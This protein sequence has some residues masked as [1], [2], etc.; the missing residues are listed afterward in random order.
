MAV[1]LATGEQAL[2]VGR[3]DAG[4]DGFDD[5]I[6]LGFL[7]VELGRIRR[8]VFEPRAGQFV[9]AGPRGEIEEGVFGVFR[10]VRQHCAGAVIR[11]YAGQGAVGFELH[12]RIGVRQE[13]R[14]EADVG[15]AAGA[16]GFAQFTQADLKADGVLALQQF[17]EVGGVGGAAA[18]EPGGV[19]PGHVVLGPILQRGLQVGDGQLG[20]LAAGLLEI[21]A[22]G[23]E[24]LG[25]QGVGRETEDGL[26]GEGLAAFR[27]DAPDAAMEFVAPWVAEI[28]FAVIDDRVRPVRDIERAVGAHLQRD[29]SEGDVAGADDV[30]E[31]LGHVAGLGCVGDAEVVE[32]EA[33]DAMGAEV[34][35][36]GVAL[37]VCAEQRA[38]DQLESAEFRIGAGADAAHQ[39]AGAF[40]G[41]EGRSREGPMHA[42]AVGAGGEERLSREVFLLAP[43]V[44]EALRVDFEAF[45]VGVVGEGDAG[46]GA[47]EAPRGLEVRVDVDRLVEVKSAIDA[48]VEGMDDVV[49]VFRAETAQDDAS[50]GEETVGVRFGEVQQFGAGADVCAA[51]II[52]GDARRDEQAVGDDAGDVG[53]SVAVGVLEE[54]DLVVAG[55]RSELGSIADHLGGQ[56]FG[57]DLRVGVRRRDPESAGGVPVHVHRLLEQRVFGEERHLQSVGKL[58]LRRWHGRQL[59]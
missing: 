14:D 1:D 41:R 52:R 24:Q 18:E 34:A 47:H 57:V 56:V 37:P 15:R 38:L 29:R 8:D 55:G 6:Q 39:S 49:R 12:A 10:Q 32:A 4:V 58:E 9:D 23:R 53:L 27:G 51:E 22:I 42:R 11:A 7:S 5:R 43:G 44:D 40:G 19:A 28:D 59:R 50:S 45:G 30:R 33:D 2:H 48:P 17:G 16:E 26:P 13:R 25:E 46:V 36:D 3:G 20:E 31:L 54:D 35:G 21:P